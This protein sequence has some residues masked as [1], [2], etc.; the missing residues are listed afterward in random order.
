MRGDFLKDS[1]GTIWFSY[2]KNIKWRDS[3][4]QNQTNSYEAKKQAKKIQQN[5]D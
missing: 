3:M 1:N 2:A 5:K 4:K